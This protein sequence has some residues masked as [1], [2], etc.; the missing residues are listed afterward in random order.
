MI[1]VE[2][3]IDDLRLLS[4]PPAHASPAA[5]AAAGGGEP[6]EPQQPAMDYR[7]IVQT[8]LTGSRLRKV[9]AHMCNHASGQVTDPISDIVHTMLTCPVQMV[10]SEVR[11]C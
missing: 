11:F 2:D 7:K 5:A 8:F 1:L 4:S 6:Q 9:F 10:I 3:D